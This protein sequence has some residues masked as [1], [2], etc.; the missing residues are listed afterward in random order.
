MQQKTEEEQGLNTLK[1]IKGNGRRRC[2]E[3]RVTVIK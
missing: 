1:V 3:M 2:N